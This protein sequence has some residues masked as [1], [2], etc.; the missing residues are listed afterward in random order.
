M[1]RVLLALSDAQGSV[2][3]REVLLDQCWDGLIVGDD[4]INRAVGELRRL[5]V[6]TGGDIEIETVPRVGYR[7][8]STDA[9]LRTAPV[10][11]H[12]AASQPVRRRA[13]LAGGAALTV[14][15]VA[16][17]ALYRSLQ[18]DRELDA[19][20]ERGR[21]L[22]ASGEPQ[23]RERATSL[24]RQVVMADPERADAWGWLA[25]VETSQPASLVAAQRA[26]DLHPRE[27]NAR[28]VMASQR[29]DLDDWVTYEVT[30]LDIIRDAPEC[31]LALAQ[32]TL[33]YQ[34]MGRCRESLR[35][36]ERA[37]AVEPFNPAH[38]ARRAMKHWI[39]GDLAK[40]DQVA[41]RAL[42]LWP[43][44]P[45]VWNARMI[46]LAF[47]GRPEA[48][49]SLLYDDQRRPGDLHQGT[50]AAW[51][52]TI[53]AIADHTADGA[54]RAEPAMM[55]AATQS[56]GM[57]ANAVMAFSY[58]GLV[59]MAYGV[60]DGLLTQKGRFVQG[61]RG[62]L[63]RDL[64]SGPVWGRTQFVFVPACANLRADA[65]FTELCRRTGHLAYWKAR[66][67]EPDPFVKGSLSL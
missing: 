3:S 35:F 63:V 10:A 59:D 58:L 60:A 49:R 11:A 51:R 22:Q 21:M 19:L 27:P 4:A 2:L 17:G 53:E 30:L 20:V 24:F 1:I 26:L 6:V 33:F 16:A 36:N 9:T 14:A 44:N 46:T 34:G 39:F 40:A 23:S 8:K 25:A 45:S 54:R 5:V 48:A 43:G 64:Y 55:A 52:A 29:L 61:A 42:Q 13:L 12:Q 7:L 62:L 50:I 37:I 38:Q 67:V 56:P 31:A 28:A 65:R 57:A 15:A 32:L 18:R 41:N 66:G 47:T